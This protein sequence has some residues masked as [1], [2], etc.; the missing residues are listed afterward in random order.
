MVTMFLSP[1]PWPMRVSFSS[2][3]MLRFCRHA[4]KMDTIKAT[5]MGIW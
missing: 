2:K 5:T 3:E 1:I 4:T